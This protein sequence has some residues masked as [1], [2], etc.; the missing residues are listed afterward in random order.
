ME[1][2]IKTRLSAVAAIGKNRELG[3]RGELIW[4]IPDDLK[5]V[6]ALTMGHTLIMGRRTHESIGR[7]LPGR[8]NIVLTRNTDFLAAGCTVVHSLE[9][10][11]NTTAVQKDDEAFI[12]GGAELYKLALP[13]IDRLY[14]TLIDATDAKAESFF[15]EFASAFVVEKQYG[16][17]E[18]AGLKY[19]WVDYIRK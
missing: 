7:P 12:F 10:A 3:K 19:E 6:K 18:H 14:L 8:S 16:Q 4:R 17:R 5:R 9:E 13:Q 2:T 15:P 1:K 11:L